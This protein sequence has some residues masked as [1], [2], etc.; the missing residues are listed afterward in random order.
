MR[1]EYYIL[2]LAPIVQQHSQGNAGELQDNAHHIMLF[3]CMNRM[4]AD[5]SGSSCGS[6][7]M[8]GSGS[9]TEKRL[10]YV[11]AH[12]GTSFSFPNGTG[13]SIGRNAFQ[14]FEILVH[15]KVA[16]PNI[17]DRSGFR[18]SVRRKPH[19]LKEVHVK[20]HIPGLV[21]P[22]PPNT[23]TITLPKS[24]V[25]RSCVDFVNQGTI[26]NVF[27]YRV[28]A[29]SLG[30]KNT[31]RMRR[32]GSDEALL[33]TRSP[34]LPQSFVPAS[35]SLLP[36]DMCSTKCTYDSTGKDEPTYEGPARTNEMCN[37]YLMYY[38]EP[39][40]LSARCIRACAFAVARQQ[41]PGDW[42]GRGRGCSSWR[43][44]LSR[45]SHMGC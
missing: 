16:I 4:S 1:D 33:I 14:S 2:G 23:P 37:V 45:R 30:R 39:H 7:G 22:I 43:R 35:F 20:V 10:L 12:K 38:E 17:K 25:W 19:D 13:I 11:W 42:R 34:E 3:G 27:A 28:H 8:G 24:D 26:A 29:H 41:H 44:D 6:E 18:I 32:E 31:L 36:S 5:S 9:C 15:Y 40:E 21:A